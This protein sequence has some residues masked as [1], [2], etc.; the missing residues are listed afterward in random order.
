M[1][2][3]TGCGECCRHVNGT[4]LD[5]GDGVC[6]N[7]DRHSRGCSIYST[8]PDICRV[9]IVMPVAAKRTEYYLETARNCNALQDL[10]G[11]PKRFRVDTRLIAR[12]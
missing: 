2:P 5:R 7:Y 1:F 8:R 3:C 11:V 6:R 12:G 10:N 9:E 4:P